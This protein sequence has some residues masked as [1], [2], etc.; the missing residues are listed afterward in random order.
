MARLD[1]A[2][3]RKVRTMEKGGWVY[4]MTNKPDGTLYIGVTADLARRIHQHREG[5]VSGFT[6]RY[7]LHRLV[8]AEHHDSIEQGIRRESRMKKWPRAWKVDLIVSQNPEWK[9]I[10]E[11]LI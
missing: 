6:K 11:T 10:Y 4:V 5:S 2:I 3:S 9:D 1:R 8:Y 7:N